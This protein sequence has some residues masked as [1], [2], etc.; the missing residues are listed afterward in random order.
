MI[1]PRRLISVG[2]ILVD[3]R[4]EAPHLPAR[5]G[6][7]VVS[8]ATPSPGGGFNVLAAAVRQGL[9]TLFAGRHGNGSHGASIRAALAQEGIATLLPAAEDGDSG[10]C[11]VLVEPDGERSFITSPGV[12]SQLGTRQLQDVPVRAGD[13]IFVSGY[14]LSYAKLGPAI[15]AWLGTLPCEI[16]LVIDPGPLVAE[17]PR[18]ILDA[19]LPRAGVLT[20]NHREARLLAGADSLREAVPRVR[21]RLSNDAL[22]VLRDGARGC[23]LAGAGVPEPFVPLPAPLARAI[24]TTGAGDAHTGVLVASLGAGYG[25]AE[26]ARR[27][28]AA[29]ALSVTRRGSATAPDRQEL[30]AFLAATATQERPQAEEPADIPPSSMEAVDMTVK[31]SRRGLTTL[32]GS[33]LALSFAPRIGQAATTEITVLNWKGYGTDE[34]TA[35]R[36]F[37]AATSIAVKHDY[38][39][40][41]PEMLTKLQTNPGAYDVV[42]INSA[43]TQQAQSAELIAPIDLAALPNAKDLAP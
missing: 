30:D 31:I 22:L 29:A 4:V 35:L 26:A 27:A 40:S 17:I 38:F 20:L 15:A 13:A 11:L 41:E 19:A 25:L 12:E 34:P 23:I 5:G 1:R 18:P 43:R 8:A 39:N 21:A 9:P 2:S 3:L 37:A 14:D 24:D 32:V 10:F 6:D 28:N 42:L 36:D 7:V 33:G 16:L